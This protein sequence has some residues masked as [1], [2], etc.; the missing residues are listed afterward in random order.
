V[1]VKAVAVTRSQ[2][3]AIRQADEAKDYSLQRPSKAASAAFIQALIAARRH[4]RTSFPRVT[5]T[6]ARKGCGDRE[7]INGQISPRLSTVFEGPAEQRATT[8]QVIMD[9]IA[10][11]SSSCLPVRWLFVVWSVTRRFTRR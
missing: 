1:L 10:I 5:H 8:S 7:T 3:S 4:A 9:F 6:C 11:L 2:S